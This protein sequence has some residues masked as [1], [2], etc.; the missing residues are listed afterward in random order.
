MQEK[1]V[2]WCLKIE[3][4]N[5]P[6]VG[7]DVKTIHKDMIKLH[8]RPCKS[9][10]ALQNASSIAGLMLTTEA[11]YDIREKERMPNMPGP[12]SHMMNG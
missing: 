5:N 11:L 6:N 7:Y 4:R 3:G 9:M 2:Q 8:H 1:K 12:E 10:T